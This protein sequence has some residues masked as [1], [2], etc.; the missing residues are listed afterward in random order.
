MGSADMLKPIRSARPALIPNPRRRLPRRERRQLRTAPPAHGSDQSP[1]GG[2]TPLRQLRDLHRIVQIR[3]DRD[4]QV[5]GLPHQKVR[6]PL[7]RA[8]R[9]Q[10]RRVRHPA[11]RARRR[12]ALLFSNI[13]RRPPPRDRRTACRQSADWFTPASAGDHASPPLRPRVLPAVRS[14]AFAIGFLPKVFDSTIIVRLFEGAAAAAPAQ[15]GE[16]DRRPSYGSCRSSGPVPGRAGW[17]C[18]GPLP[19]PPAGRRG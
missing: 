5:D 14:A 17:R 9:A 11:F 2:L 18:R 3:A 15:I 10:S 1:G 8:L 4:G 19:G 16:V 13:L 6:A 12:P 7:V